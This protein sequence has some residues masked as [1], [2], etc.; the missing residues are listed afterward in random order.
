MK[1]WSCSGNE[2]SFLSSSM[3]LE[4]HD[5]I[6]N[7]SSEDLDTAHWREIFFHGRMVLGCLSILIPSHHEIIHLYPTF[8]DPAL[9]P[10]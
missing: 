6:S 2:N 8:D 1:E 3:S 10:R 4:E 5:S 9:R 7:I